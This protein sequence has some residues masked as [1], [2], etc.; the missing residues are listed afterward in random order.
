MNLD[1]DKYI[2]H[3]ALTRDLAL[4][5][6][7]MPR[8]ESPLIINSF[9]SKLIKIISGFRRS[10]KSSITKFTIQESLRNKFIKVENILYLNFEDYELMEINDV[11]KL[12]ELYEIFINFMSSTGTKLLVFDEVQKVKNWDKFIRTLYER[13]ACNNQIILTG[14]NSEMLSSELGSNLAGRFIEFKL[15][16]FS[17]KEFLCFKSFE[18]PERICGK[19]F[20]NLYPKLEPLFYEYLKEGGLP[21][22]YSIHNPGTKLSYAQNI[23]SK[24]ILDDIVDRFRIRNNIAIGKIFQFISQ[25]PGKSLSYSKISK[26]F[27]QLNIEIHEETVIEYIEYLK[28]S[29]AIYQID[30][31]DYSNKK[32]FQGNKKFYLVDIGLAHLYKGITKNFSMLLENLVFL[33]LR[34]NPEIKNIFY[35]SNGFEID[36]VTEDWQGALALYQVTQELNANNLERELKG[37]VQIDQFLKQARQTILT[38]NGL[39]KVLTHQGQAIQQVNLLEFLLN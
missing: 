13:N 26:Y 38:L 23:I 31:F 33:K 15:Q 30:K 21:E 22:I 7:I 1:Q 28:Q 5:E 6:P 17:F 19:T 12:A 34:R 24:V 20:A 11:D 2:K 16:P 29:F 8:E 3:I 37:F 32:I 25:N 27:K 14:S 35:I 36:F 18:L 4:S 10:G 39:S 9:D